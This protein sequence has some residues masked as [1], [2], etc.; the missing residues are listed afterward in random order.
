MFAQIQDSLV[1]IERAENF[2]KEH[3][4]SK[5]NQLSQLRLKPSPD[6]GF[7]HGTLSWS[8]STEDN[9]INGTLNGHP[10]A[11]NEFILSD[12]DVKFASG[13][14]DIIT[15]ATGS[16]KSSMLLALLGEMTLTKGVVCM[17]AAVDRESLPIDSESGLV[18][19]VAYCAQEAWLTNDTIRS[20]ILFGSPH[21]EERYRAVLDACALTVDLE[22]LVEG[23]HRQIG[24]RG[25]TLSGGQKK[26]IALARAV[27]SNAC[28]L[29]LDDYLSA[30]DT[31]TSTWIFEHCIKRPLL[32]AR[33]CIL[34]THNLIHAAA[35]AQLLVALENGKVTAAGPPYDLARSGFHFPLDTLPTGNSNEG[36]QRNRQSYSTSLRAGTRP[37]KL[38]ES[39]DILEQDSDQPGEDVIVTD[40]VKRD[41]KLSWNDVSRY[42]AGMGS[43]KVWSLLEF[44]FIGQQFGAIATNWWVRVLSDAY[45]EAGHKYTTGC[46]DRMRSGNSSSH[47]KLTPERINLNFYFGMYG[48]IIGLYMIVGL[49]RMLLVSFGSLQASAEVHRRLIKSIMNARLKFFHDTSFGQ[50]INRFSTDLQTVNQHLAVLVIATLHFLGALTGIIILIAMTTPSFLGPG[51]AISIG[52]YFIGAV[53]V[54][55]SRD[56]KELESIERAPLSQ[57]ISETLSGITTIRA[58]GAMGQYSTGNYAQIYRANRPSFFAAATERWLAIRRGLMGAFVSLF[59]GSFAISSAGKLSTGAIGLSMSYAIV[60]SKHVLWLVRYHSSNSQNLTA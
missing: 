48:L 31:H 10:G 21:N 51:V 33:T 8:S 59:A 1:S 22:I 32:K 52:Y 5:Y 16:R 43:W 54:S 34:I 44:S 39:H 20:N 29:L 13:H 4:P 57:H 37:E 56:L 7:E 3:E 11:D 14:L 40:E 2:L 17:P 42:L 35:D 55:A 26:R 23:E 28:H 45:T 58:F 30:V 19:S 12:L 27:Y 38:K 24:E 36:S 25:V 15:G 18:D 9:V 60:F 47:S 6:I 46:S 50:I 49:S 53:Y 41:E